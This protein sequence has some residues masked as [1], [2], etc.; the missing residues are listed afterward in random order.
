MTLD[1]GHMEQR[2][3]LAS[4][5]KAPTGIQGF[6]DISGGG[7]PRGRPTLVCGGPGT[8]KTLFAMEFVVRGAADLGE[9][10]VFVSFAETR[11]ELVANFAS[12]GYDIPG[13]IRR[14]RLAVEEFRLERGELVEAGPYDLEGM[15][16]R[17]DHLIGSVGAKRV[18]LD[19]LDTLFGGVPDRFILRAELGRLFRWLK[20]RGVTAVITGERGETSLTREGIE[21]YVSDCVVLLGQ[22]IHERTITRHLRIVKYRGTEHGTNEYPFLI[23]DDGML[24]LPLSSSSL[25]HNVSSE[26][27]SLGV[28][29]LDQML[30][31]QGVFRG[32]AVLIT[33]SAGTG[34]SSIAAS[35]VH[36]AC[37]RGE[38]CLYVSFE[39][40]PRQILRNM[41]SIGLDL[42]PWCQQ[43]LLS[44]SSGR[45]SRAGL[46][47]HL[48]SLYRQVE[49]FAPDL[50]VID[51]MSNL[52]TIGTE[53]EVRSM[54]AR[55]IDYLKSR[56]TTALFVSLT[57]EEK[58][59]IHFSSHVSSLMDTWLA[60]ESVVASGERNRLITVHKSRGMAHSN[61]VRE[62]I[63]TSRGIELADVYL[64]PAGVVTGAAR[65]LQEAREVADAEERAQRIALLERDIVRRRQTTEAQMGAIQAELEG[66]EER[67]RG[68]I[69]RERREE[70]ESLRARTEMVRARQADPL[71]GPEAAPSPLPDQGGR[72][73]T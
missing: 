6:D 7:L 56:L 39:E 68:L 43:G 31:G 24:I 45:P 71:P 47:M 60:V 14:E 59:Y 13:L 57:P 5:P 61:Q 37:G 3:P 11:D 62:F 29:R 52:I 15:F 53:A 23:H 69:A 1:A 48:V 26:R 51:P 21:E 38:R 40:A 36:A 16:V 19:S 8:G 10:G 28:P 58:Q 67:L 20:A 63:M 17:L 25:D 18:A 27:L 35:A 12:L 66:E 64:G 9:P 2:P 44:F 46:E 70:E 34:K 54:L 72:E 41:R 73:A 30:G 49:R 22:W 42:E 50:V 55:L 4:I 65:R 33:G 32:A